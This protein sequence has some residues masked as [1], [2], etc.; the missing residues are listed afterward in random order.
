[1]SAS[2]YPN[3]A[4]AR[5]RILPIYPPEVR[6]DIGIVECA[7]C[8]LVLA[9]VQLQHNFGFIPRT[10]KEDGEPVEILIMTQIGPRGN[11]FSSFDGS[12]STET[13]PG[14]LS[15][16]VQ[17]CLDLAFVNTRTARLRCT[18]LHVLRSTQHRTPLCP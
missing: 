9:L 12:S 7:S 8:L 11:R 16:P 3:T 17:F 4:A 18:V 5:G 14:F 10:M 2:V 6:Q 1:M 13:V 15:V